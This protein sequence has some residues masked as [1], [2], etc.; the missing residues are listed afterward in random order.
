CSTFIKRIRMVT[1]LS[2]EACALFELINYVSIAGIVC[3]FGILS[4]II[5][6]FV[7]WKHGFTNS[8]TMAFF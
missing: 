4:N 2:N 8:V 7:F 1:D 3:T 5:N 6:L